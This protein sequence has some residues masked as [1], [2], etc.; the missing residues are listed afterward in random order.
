MISRRTFLFASGLAAAEM[1]PDH[2]IVIAPYTLE[3]SDRQTLRTTAYN[4]QVPGPLLRLQE[5]RSV[6]IEVSNQS[7]FPEVVHWHGLFLPPEVDGSMEEGT[8]MIA[9]GKTVRY[10]FSPTPAGFRWF[11]THTMAGRDLTRALYSGQH[12]LLFVESKQQST[13]Y[14][15]EYFLSL[16]DWKGRLVGSDDGSM[17]PEYSVSTVNGKVLGA[18]EPLRVKQEQ[19]ILLHLLNASA[20]ETHWL[21]CAGH[22]FHVIALDGNP[23]PQDVVVPML[24]L[25]PAE[26]IS[27]VVETTNPGVWVLG[28]VRTHV[29]KRGMGVVLEY[30]GRKGEAHWDQ[31]QSLAWD[32]A[33]FSTRPSQS[34]AKLISLV[35]DS[36]FAGHGALDQWRING[37]PFSKA[38]PILI[39]KGERY[40]L[41]YVN[42][43][44][45]PH[46]VHLHRHLFELRRFAGKG[47]I[48]GIWKDTVLVEP[49]SEAEVEFVAD[50]PGRT[51]FHCHQQDHMDM[52]F[53]VLFDYV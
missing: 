17:N 11:H 8:P 7:S 23:V 40:R 50:Q 1:P 51:L 9:P 42:H 36:K 2:Q 14:D 33:Q 38:A 3:Y 52:G 16:Q 39:Q 6:T 19:R 18:G 43:S 13:A 24:R 44:S 25:A 41:R 49:N 5:G 28:E 31:P 35:F 22:Q 29:R 26:R 45:D 20:T 34:N 32:Y 10:T 21:S 53:M 15:A 30:A 48:G 12:G 4:G 47:E 46:P 37:K 27:A